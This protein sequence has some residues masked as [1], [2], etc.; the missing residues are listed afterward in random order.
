MRRLLVLLVGLMAA[1]ASGADAVAYR[2]RL[3][4]AL[5]AACCC[6]AETA[7]EGPGEHA[8]VGARCCCDREIVAARIAPALVCHDA[9][10]ASAPARVPEALP[11]ARAV[12]PPGPSRPLV[13]LK[14]SL[15]V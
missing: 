14:R 1:R 3:D 13:L 15:L 12:G 11:T 8:A 6:P 7:K 2:C 5:R 10:S 4:G 9:G